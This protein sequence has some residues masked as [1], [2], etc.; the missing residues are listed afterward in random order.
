MRKRE[1]SYRVPDKLPKLRRLPN[2]GELLFIQDLDGEIFPVL[3]LEVIYVKT[4]KGHQTKKVRA[5]NVLSG[6]TIFNCMP[7]DLKYMP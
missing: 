5:V 4:K 2:V 7:H 1:K 6:N 3:V